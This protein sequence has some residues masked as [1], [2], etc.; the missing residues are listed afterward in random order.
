MEAIKKNYE[1]LFRVND[2]KSGGS[3]YL[4]SKVG[5]EK[6][7]RFLLFSTFARLKNMDL[8]ERKNRL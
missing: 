5:D 6:P 3:F 7:S 1:H 2:K 4:Q 8:F